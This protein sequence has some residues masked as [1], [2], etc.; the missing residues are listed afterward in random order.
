[1]KVGEAFGQKTSELTN[2]GSDWF[3]QPHLKMGLE[4]E[5]EGC[6]G[7][8]YGQAFGPYTTKE[9]GSLRNYGCEFVFTQ[10][11]FGKDLE[12][13][14]VYMADFAQQK[15]FQVTSR[16][17][18]HAHMD[19]RELEAEQ[20][21]TLLLLYAVYEDMFYRFVG[22]DRRDGNFCV[23]WHRAGGEIGSYLRFMVSDSKETNIASYRKLQRYSGLNLAS[24]PKYGSIEFRHLGGST[25]KHRVKDWLN[26]IMSLH[27][28]AQEWTTVGY[29]VLLRLS[30]QGVQASAQGIF[31][32]WFMSYYRQ[33]WA[34]E[35]ILVAQ[36]LLSR[37]G[38]LKFKP[39]WT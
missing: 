35:G 29:D 6:A 3:I 17:S 27:R 20:L 16:C 18:V 15:K 30:S 8:P 38:N 26:C 21:M 2:R 28:A 23:P 12:N 39:K 4:F 14:I 36:D 1:M 34:E 24:L 7:I 32:P 13:A 33:E 31:P 10:P 5:Y 9:D 25:D 37:S 22:D 11:L 19:V